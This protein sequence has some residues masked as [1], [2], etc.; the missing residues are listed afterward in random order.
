MH[1]EIRR[2]TINGVKAFCRKGSTKGSNPMTG[3]TTYFMNIGRP[4]ITSRMD[5]ADKSMN[6]FLITDLICEY[7]GVLSPKLLLCNMT[8]SPRFFRLSNNPYTFT[9]CPT[10]A[11]KSQS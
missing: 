4:K 2:I 1:T 9:W 11:E 7:F 8:Y 6:L 5:N 10:R 3:M